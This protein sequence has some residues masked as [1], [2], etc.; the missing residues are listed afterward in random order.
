MRIAFVPARRGLTAALSSL[1]AVAF[2]QTPT[3]SPDAPPS[4]AAGKPRWEA[5]FVVGA[6]RV[7]DYPGAGQSHVR[8]LVAP[9]VIYRGPVLNVD[10]EGVRGRLFASPDFELDVAASAAFNARDN[11]ARDGMPGLDYLFG[12]G[13]QLVY[14]GLRRVPGSPTVHAKAK[15]LLSTDFGGFDG[16]GASFEPELRWRFDRVGGTRSSLVLGIQPAWASRALHR[17]FYQVDPQYATTA[18]P[19]HRA[20]GGYLGTELKLTLSRRAGDSL[21]WFVA[22]RAMSLHGS[23]NESSPLL[24]RDATVDVGAGLLW[25]PWRSAQRVAD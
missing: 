6:G 18:R 22:L 13:P 10:G 25:T 20:R 15:A 9:F 21:S 17:Y 8:A 7:S 1:A 5:G 16:R 11:D 23:A 3:P 12:V 4:P 14:K 2:A 19:A 24:R